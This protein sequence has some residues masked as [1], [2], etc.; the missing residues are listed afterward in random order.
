MRLL[1]PD[2]FEEVFVP[3]RGKR[4]GYISPYGNVGDQLIEW[5]T[6]QLFDVFGIDWR[7]VDPQLP[8]EP[9]VDELVFGGGGNMGN[10]YRNNWE[11]RGQA[12]A[13]G[14]PMTI[15]PQSFNSAEDRSYQRVYVRER[16]SLS[17]CGHATL[18]PDL[19]LGLD[20]HVAGQPTNELGVFLRRDRERVGWSRWFRRDPAKL[21]ATPRAY[22]ELAACH[23]RIVTDRLHFAICGLLL[24][25]DVTLLPNDYHK[26]RAMYEAWLEGLGCRFARNVREAVGRRFYWGGAPVRVKLPSHGRTRGFSASTGPHGGPPRNPQTRGGDRRW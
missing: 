17:Y 9:D 5:A 8:V 21:C 26:N 4:I 11:L 24:G 19:A 12:L 13:L 14:R 22:L 3:L 6:V 20:C 25:R 10:R 15:L 1:T 7:R 18:A 16:A 23:D 2:A